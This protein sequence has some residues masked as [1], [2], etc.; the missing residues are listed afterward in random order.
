MVYEPTQVEA[1]VSDIG[2]IASSE[3]PSKI[4]SPIF[5]VEYE[6]QNQLSDTNMFFASRLTAPKPDLDVN[7][8]AGNIIIAKQVMLVG[9]WCIKQRRW[10]Y[11]SFFTKI[12]SRLVTLKSFDSMC[13]MK[14]FQQSLLIVILSV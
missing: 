13:E 5:S 14:T 7:L 1:N 9:V 4:P 12:L 10:V 6:L 2:S 11:F 3:S 8:R